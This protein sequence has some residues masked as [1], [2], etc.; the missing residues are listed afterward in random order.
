MIVSWGRG[1]PVEG[2]SGFLPKLPKRWVGGGG[3][4]VGR[5]THCTF[6]PALPGKRVEDPY[7]YWTNPEPWHLPND[8]FG[9]WTRLSYS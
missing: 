2:G 4:V 3:G 9:P 7:I 5:A 6:S 8:F 1:S